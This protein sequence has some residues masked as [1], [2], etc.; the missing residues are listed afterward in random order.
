[1]LRRTLKFIKV[2]VIFTDILQK[3]LQKLAFQAKIEDRSLYLIIEMPT[4]FH[5]DDVVPYSILFFMEDEC[6]SVG[7]NPSATRLMNIS[8]IQSNAGSRE[9]KRVVSAIGGGHS[10]YWVDPELGMDNLCEAKHHMLTRNTRANNID[11]RLQPNPATREAI[12]T[13]V[14]VS[15]VVHIC[16]STRIL[17]VICCMLVSTKL[18]N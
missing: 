14:N 7:V 13:I 4:V 18:L 2:F 6:Q 11:W 5:K 10:E 16:F 15:Y 1:M 12:E 17:L 3:F 9:Q 8:S